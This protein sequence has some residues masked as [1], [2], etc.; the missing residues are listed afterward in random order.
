MRMTIELGKDNKLEL[1]LEYD[2]TKDEVTGII[3]ARSWCHELD[4]D[5][6]ATLPAKEKYERRGLFYNQVN[7]AAVDL[8][9]SML[10]KSTKPEVAID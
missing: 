6:E 4:A 10:K 1:E 7:E 8:R 2:T 9:E 5:L 3:K